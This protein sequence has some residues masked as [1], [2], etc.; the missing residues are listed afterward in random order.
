MRIRRPS[1]AMVVSIIAL[2][3]STT[4]S[5][6]A[7]VNFARNAGH[8]DGLNAVGASATLGKAKGKL[9]ATA[10]GGS[11]PGQIPGKFLA[12]V[13]HSDPFLHAQEVTDNATGATIDIAV[14][15]LGKITATCSDQAG[16]V[17][18]E[19]PSSRIQYVNSTPGEINIHRRVGNG[20]GEVT[21]VAPNTVNEFTVNG[22][23]DFRIHLA[24][25]ETNAI[26]EGVV[27]QTGAR[28]P[29]G[30]C[31]AFGVQSVVE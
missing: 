2:V 27:R 8:V 21:T 19:D 4:G 18:T 3:M 17:G 25:L 30:A 9:V 23:N 14:T 10:R 7:A 20:T 16:A 15:P 11:N 6:V 24:S 1:P 22:S 28:T 12:G 26:V 31:V 13:P 5:A 29:A